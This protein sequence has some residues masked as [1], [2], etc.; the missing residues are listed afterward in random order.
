VPGFGE[1]QFGRQAAGE[2]A[3]SRYALFDLIPE[4]YK[5]QD[6]GEVGAG[7]L[8]AFQEALRPSFD[9]LRH[10][11]RDFG[12]L[13]DP[14]RVR[15]QFSGARQL[16]LGAAIQQLGEL[17]QHGADGAVG[18]ARE[19][20]SPTV[21]FT[22]DSNGKV[23][24]IRGSSVASNNRAFAI[25]AVVNSMAVIADPLLTPD[26][27]PF[28]WEIRSPV[29]GADD[30]VLV[31]VQE[32]DVAELAAGWQV[33]D[34]G[35]EYAVLDR[36][37]FNV[38]TSER[39]FLTEREGQDGAVDGFGRFVTASAA[40]TPRQVGQVLSLAGDF[41]KGNRRYAR[42]AGLSGTT[43]PQTLTLVDLETGAPL[44]LTPEDGPF[45]W[46][47]LPRPR[48][49][50]RG[51]LPP[52]GVVEQEGGD[53]AISAP[54]A[55]TATLRAESAAFVVGRDEGKTLRLVSLTQPN[56]NRVVRITAVLD[57]TGVTVAIVAPSYDAGSPNPL[58]AETGLFWE[59]R[60][61]TGPSDFTYVTARPDSILRHLAR[62]FG[63]DID[64][65]E[66]EQVQR[67]WVKNVATWLDLKG[68]ARGYAVIGRVSGFEI[69]TEGLFRVS[70]GVYDRLPDLYR[71]ELRDLETGRHGATG[72]FAIVDGEVVFSADE[73][74]FSVR[75]EAR[76]VLIEDATLPENDR[77]YTI[78]RYVSP[79][80]VV[81]RAE[82]APT[83]P[84]ASNGA[85]TWYVARLYATRPPTIPRYDEINTDLLAWVVENLGPAGAAFT[86]D[87]FCWEDDF[88]TQVPLTVTAVAA[89]I[90]NREWLV[91]VDGY[92]DVVS[93]VGAW[94]ITDAAGVVFYLE[95]VPA[96]TV[97]G[98]PPTCTFVVRA[99]QAPAL[100]AAVLS[101]TCPTQLMCDYCGASKALA[102]ITV[103]AA[104]GATPLALERFRERILQRLK[105]VTPAHVE[106]I[107][108]FQ[109]ALEAVFG[110]TGEGV[111]ATLEPHAVA[112]DLY[113]PLTAFYDEIPADTY[114]DGS[115]TVDG[116]AYNYTDLYLRASIE[117]TIP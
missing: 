85:L 110:P 7:M 78:E 117:P 19:F 21:R 71:V 51:R 48:L 66:P 24:V 97:V 95:T 99:S 52:R 69:T 58:V 79:G 47:L 23:L 1:G 92:A 33:V 2:W 106:L 11:I 8:E 68:T 49:R 56:N 50:L 91:T 9:V 100:G 29:V 36:Q 6:A 111:Q 86:P 27:G 57:T 74:L 109:T 90:P 104:I 72:T 37:R 83:L 15:T 35:A 82:D 3:W 93:G 116:L 76:Q 26:A 113:A 73:A 17:E 89:T 31:E 28:Q 18:T 80:S 77:Y 40:F 41:E 30:T 20:T 34:A 14:L 103:G 32:G 39:K 84:D 87:T 81:V 22:P 98:P 94:K 13:R 4:V 61:A 105:D 70:Q 60:A 101:Y 54:S 65:Q 46:A 96:V 38:L 44:T 115:T 75:D 12:D 107:P 42:L 16:R 10:Q 67:S 102:T 62:D 25:G 59:L 53:L 108:R 43:A 112:A 55:D 45:A 63:I 5:Q 114:G 64:T 88:S